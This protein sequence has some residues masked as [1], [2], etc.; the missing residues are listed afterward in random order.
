MLDVKSRWWSDRFKMCRRLGWK[1]IEVWQWMV[2]DMRT[3]IRRVGRDDWKDERLK[4]YKLWL[5]FFVT[6]FVV[7]VLCG[8]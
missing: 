2:G 8:G 1:T 6:F 3:R 4:S 5:C 7:R